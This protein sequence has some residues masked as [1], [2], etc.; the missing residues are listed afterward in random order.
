MATS[1][2]VSPDPARGDAASRILTAAEQLFAEQGYAAVSISAIAE[3]AGIS[4]AN[5]F[6]HFSSKRELYLAVVR[7]ACRGSA[8]RLEYLEAQIDN[9]PER[10]SAYAVK[11]LDGMLRRERLHRLMLRE[12]I[13]EDDDSLAKELAE[14]V[15][16]A[17]FARLVAILRNGQARGGLR[18]DFDPAMA[19]LALIGA[20]YFFLQSRNVM[21][22]LPDAGCAT[23]PRRYSEL[24][25]DLL[26]RGM[27]PRSSAD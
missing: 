2:A 24:L 12:L 18:K 7:H 23:D 15:F 26:L 6:H 10:F 27:L 16:G 22:H 11:A 13:T 19:A 5:V 20:N 3:R 4:K 21:Q 8:E 17:N 14:R 9:F 25:A 1:P